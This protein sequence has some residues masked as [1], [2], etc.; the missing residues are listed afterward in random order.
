MN[1]IKKMV[2]LLV[3]LL[4][5]IVGCS[6]SNSK[7]DYKEGFVIAKENNSVLVVRNKVP[8]FN[9]QL[10][11]ILENVKPNAIW[12]SVG[13]ADYNTIVVGDHINFNITNGVVDHSYPAQA[14]ADSIKKID[15]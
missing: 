11:E 5:T 15:D 2:V 12:L 6:S 4:L 1:N 3:V 7:W 14:Q 9:A 10:S 13:Q 8:N